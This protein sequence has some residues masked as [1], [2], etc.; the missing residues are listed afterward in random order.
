MPSNAINELF[1]PKPRKQ[2]IDNPFVK[3]TNNYR[4]TVKNILKKIFTMYFFRYLTYTN[5]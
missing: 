1:H 2:N 5:S 3:D 4:N